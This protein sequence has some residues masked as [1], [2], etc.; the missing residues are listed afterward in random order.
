MFSNIFI[1]AILLYEC[2]IYNS[3]RYW[4]RSHYNARTRQVVTC[5]ADEGKIHRRSLREAHIWSFQVMTIDIAPTVGP[6]THD[7]CTDNRFGP[8]HYSKIGMWGC[9]R[10]LAVT[11]GSWLDLYKMYY[12]DPNPN[13]HPYF[14]IGVRS[15]SAM[16]RQTD[17]VILAMHGSTIF[18]HIFNS[19][20]RCFLWHVLSSAYLIKLTI[21]LLLK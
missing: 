5:Q 14:G 17:I 2:M 11:M 16:N 15:K 20:W 21:R 12:P 9:R 6:L 1:T 13:S 18:R 8:N 19:V 3:L 4:Y 7:Y 10:C